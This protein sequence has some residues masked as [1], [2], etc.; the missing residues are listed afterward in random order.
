MSWFAPSRALRLFIGVLVVALV[1]W[2]ITGIFLSIG[3][4]GDDATV[5]MNSFSADYRLERTASGQS[6]MVV[7]EKITVTFSGRENHG[8]YRVLPTSYR[9]RSTSLHSLTVTQGT[10]DARTLI[11][12]GWTSTRVRIGSANRSVKGTVSYRI[13]Y[14]YDGVIQNFG[15]GQ[16]LYWDVNG[17]GWAESFGRV[18]ATLT[19][20]ADLAGSLT[21]S[22]ACYA[23]GYGG[24]DTCT[25]TRTDAGEAVR[26]TTEAVPVG[27]QQT[28]TFAVGFLPGTVATEGLSTPAVQALLVGVGGALLTAVL[29]LILAVRAAT[30]RRRWM[31]YDPGVVQFTPREDLPPMLAA[32][33]IGA[34]GRGLTAEL[35][36]A[37]SEGWVELRGGGSA[38]APLTATVMDWPEEWSAASRRA[39]RTVFPRRTGEEDVQ[40]QL[41]GLSRREV[42]ELRVLAQR[43]GLMW[44]PDV[45]YRS[46]QLLFASVLLPGG[47]VAIGILAALPF[48]WIVVP[49]GVT[50]LSLAVLY[51]LLMRWYSL[52]SRGEAA[53]RYLNGLR[54]FLEASE[55]DR[56]Q[57]VQGED[58]SERR[59]PE[60]MIPIFEK[61]LPY[62]VALGL[63][64]SWQRAVGTELLPQLT[65]LPEGDFA[66]IARMA[67]VDTY[68]SSSYH[69]T[70][71]DNS[72]EA[73]IGSVLGDWGKGISNTLNSMS[74]GSDG[75][76]SSSRSGRRSSGGG[77]SSG[78][79]FAGGGG[80]GGGGG[81]G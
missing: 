41:A 16:E 42:A 61:L 17:T 73:T 27:A 6:R 34:P 56:M 58:T 22:A 70:Y 25:I 5:R 26:F 72:S 64:H 46:Q 1:S 51:G 50:G 54:M 23:G 32:S 47:S 76:R 18:Q 45:G 81:S 9:G 67:A 39:L 14:V 8:I 43:D 65:W 21:G 31:G 20:P 53:Y 35:L 69:S 80:G 75:G 77:G 71:I 11:T 57:M 15:G 40:R 38:G 13:S 68:S 2:A 4:G 63:E 37:A 78:G 66:P 7:T 33:L 44:L 3:Q 60:Q 28:Q 48:W 24:T 29:A 19:V 59:G 10:E 79:G 49:L 52:G 12:P 36:R 30:R 62:A 55:V 74:S